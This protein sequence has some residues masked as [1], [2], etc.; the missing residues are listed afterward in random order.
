MRFMSRFNDDPPIRNVG[1]STSA[2]SSVGIPTPATHQQESE[3]RQ[4][5]PYMCRWNYSQTPV[6]ILPSDFN[7]DNLNREW[8]GW[9]HSFL[10]FTIWKRTNHGC[11]Y[12]K[13]LSNSSL[14]YKNLTDCSASC[15]FV[16]EH[17]RKWNFLILLQTD[18]L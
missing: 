2:C 4:W 16:M 1:L 10:S 15:F 5:M 17:F 7:G 8:H 3:I 18:E 14:Y 13:V 11:S 12:E 6:R 9:S